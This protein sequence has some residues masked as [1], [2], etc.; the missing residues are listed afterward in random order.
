MHKRDM[1]ICILGPASK[2]YTTGLNH[3]GNLRPLLFK[4]TRKVYA[5]VNTG[6]NEDP[7]VTT[8][9]CRVQCHK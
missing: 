9:I 6:L 3:K 7:I 1:L 5:L 4:M 8:S 2:L